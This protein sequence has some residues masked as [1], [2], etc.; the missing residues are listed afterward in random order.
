MKPTLKFGLVGLGAFAPRLARQIVRVAQLTAVYDPVQEKR[1][2]FLAEEGFRVE[3]FD[4]Y[5]SLLRH[6][7]I[8]A[9][10]V[11]SPNFTY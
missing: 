5:Q 7:D 10:V 2:S 1:D 8:E 11:T 6:G 9:V 3:V 4:D